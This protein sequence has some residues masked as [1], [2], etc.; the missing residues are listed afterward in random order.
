MDAATIAQIAASVSNLLLVVI[1]GYGYYKLYHISQRSLD[2]MVQ[3]R[4]AGG[5]PQMVIEADY[6]RLPEIDLVVRNVGGG[7]AKNIKFDFSATIKSST[8]FVLSDLFYLKNGMDFLGPGGEIRCLWDD[9]QSLEEV[10]KAEDLYRG[11]A[12]KIGYEDMTGG[13]FETDLTINPLLYEGIRNAERKNIENVAEAAEKIANHLLD[14]QAPAEVE[15]SQSSEE[16]EQSDEEQHRD[17]YTG[18][19]RTTPDWSA[20]EREAR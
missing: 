10:L 5:R 17:G 13:H 4:V 12:V 8:G 7:P 6:Q 19:G 9:L 20:G 16:W 14:G 15:Q 18:S 2:E 1:F 11:I 3:E